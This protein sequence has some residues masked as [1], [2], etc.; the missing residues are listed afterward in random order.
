[1]LCERQESGKGIFTKN[2]NSLSLIFV[3]GFP[4]SLT[5]AKER[6]LAPARPSYV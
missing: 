3:S 6:S 5:I 1:M 4:I 2:G